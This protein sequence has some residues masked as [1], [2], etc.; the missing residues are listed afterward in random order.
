[1]Q[2]ITIYD[3]LLLPLYLFL[4]YI[5]VKRR[6]LKF[7]DRELRKIFITAFALRMLGAIGYSL[8]V[9]Y[10]YGYGDS[11]T[12][13]EGGNYLRGLLLTDINNI[14]YIFFSAEEIQRLYSFQEGRV[15]GLNGYIATGS[16]LAIMKA[17]AI[18]SLVTFNKYLVTSI[19]FGMF[20]FMGQWKLFMVFNGINKGKYQKLLAFAVL[21][22]PA[23]WFWG[24]GLL[25][26]S[27][28]MGGIG[29]IISILY[30]AIA[31]KR[32]IAK[33]WILL[34]LCVYIVY[35]IKSYI[36]VILV[37]VVFFTILFTFFQKVKII[38]VK[39]ALIALTI[40]GIYFFLSYSDFSEQIND[41]AEESVSQIENFQKN[42]QVTQ[43]QDESSKAGFEM[44][45]IGSSFSSMM[46]RSPVVILSCLYRPF[47]WESKKL[48]IFFSSLESTL[49]LLSTL[50]VFFKTRIV[51]FFWLLFA[52]PYIFFCF[53]IT[54]LFALII[55]FTTFNFGTMV[56][57]KIVLLPFMYFMLVNMYART[58]EKRK[59]KMTDTWRDIMP[60]S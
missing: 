47:L 14:K 38:P 58:M 35:V 31:N 5:L 60:V 36:I 51:G 12:Y 42:Y 46:A 13:Y 29:F 53:L 10:Y 4:F 19:F 2:H 17:S 22:T 59:N 24:S 23:I 18:A 11:F 7:E 41:L 26:E 32:V 50:F 21:Y 57:Y 54:V 28:C 6:S 1:M 48:I 15:G 49:L 9:Q 43:Q 39:F 16:S 56:R 34:A 8:M 55:G 20:S 3:Y 33:D 40:L 44:A 45:N 37:T 30:N 25:K 52:D 27:L